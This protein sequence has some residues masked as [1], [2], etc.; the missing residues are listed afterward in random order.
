MRRFCTILIGLVFFSAGLFKLIDPVGSSLIVRSYLEFFHLGFLGGLSGVAAFVLSSLEALTGLA[1]LRGAWRRITAKVSM[2]LIGFFTVIT[3]ILMLAQ[4]KMDCGCFG[5]A[6]HLSHTQTFIKNIVLC[7]LAAGAFIPLPKTSSKKNA[8][9]ILSVITLFTGIYSLFFLPLWDFTAFGAGDR[10]YDTAHPFPQLKAAE[11]GFIYEKNGTQKEFSLDA[12]PDST[13]T[14]VSVADVP[15]AETPANLVPIAAPDG[16]PMDSVLLHGK[17]LA[18]SAYEPEKL[19][20]KDWGRAAEL[21]A[22]AAENGTQPVLLTA[23]AEIE[24][25][26]QDLETVQ[27]MQ[28]LM[29]SYFSDHKVLMTFNRSNGGAVLLDEG[30]I[31]EKWSSNGYPTAVKMQKIA[32][33]GPGN[34]IIGSSVPG[35][36]CLVFFMM[37]AIIISLFS[38]RNRRKRIV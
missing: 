34:L 33:E 7:A 18:I 15:E 10:L 35:R 1:L 24:N 11:P 6:F 36:I 20:E 30:L 17:V 4:P 27:R 37:A 29:V 21:L 22:S 23:S 9:I 28:L 14:F 16:S 5:E 38:Y 12:L 8:T 32:A 13:W 2:A 25:L 3:F 26:L 19:S 31:V